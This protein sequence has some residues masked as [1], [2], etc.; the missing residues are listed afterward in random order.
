MKRFAHANQSASHVM[1]T[2]VGMVVDVAVGVFQHPVN[3][4]LTPR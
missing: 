3:D 4:I 2:S 1:P